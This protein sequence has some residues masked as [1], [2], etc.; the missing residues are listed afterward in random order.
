VP[1]QPQHLARLRARLRDYL[2]LFCP[3]AQ[4]VWDV[5]LC[6]HEACLAAMSHSRSAPEIEVFLGFRGADLQTVVRVRGR[7][8][9]IVALESELLPDSEDEQGRG[10]FLMAQLAD[11]AELRRNGGLEVRL[12][13]R[14]ALGPDEGHEVGESGAV[15]G[16][17]IA[18]EAAAGR[19]RSV[20]DEDR[21]GVIFDNV[22]EGVAL[23]ELVEHEGRPVDYRI[24]QTN[25][26]FR[27]QTG[28]D[29]HGIGSS[30]AGELYG[31]DEPPYLEQ[32]AALAAG[33]VPRVFEVRAPAT[34]RDLRL[35]ALALGAGRFATITEDVTVRERA[36]SMLDEAAA[37]LE[38]AATERRRLRDALT[39]QAETIGEREA[40][41]AAQGRRSAELS[42]ELA[43]LE[44][45]QRQGSPGGNGNKPS[46]PPPT[47][48]QLTQAQELVE[49]VG[50]AKALNAIDR[51]LRSALDV[52][53][54]MQRALEGA[55]QALAADAGTIVLR[56]GS[57]WVVTYQWGFSAAE[58][59]LRVSG[60]EAADAT[61]A[62]AQG[63]PFA[64][65]DMQTA[66]SDVGFPGG[67]D[68]RGVL[69]VPLVVQEAV[70]G[71]LLFYSEQER[72]F[73]NAEIDFGRKLGV[74][75]ALTLENA[76]LRGEQH[77][78]AATLQQRLIHSLPKVAGLEMAAVSRSASD[79]ALLGGAF[80]D[81]IALQDGLMLALI[82][83][84]TGRGIA[85]AV[86]TETMRSSFRTLALI[87]SAP[88]F[89]LRQLNRSLLVEP[90]KDQP[91]T[92]L[93]A[94]FDLSAG[95]LSLASAG[96]PPAVLVS[97]TGARLLEV[98][99]GPP[100]GVLETGYETRQQP[101][102]AGETLVL[103]TKGVTEARHEGGELRLLALLD[104][105]KT[106]EP[107]ALAD[108]LLGA[109]T[110]D[111]GTLQAAVQI[112]TVRRRG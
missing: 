44:G 48:G 108:H 112:V 16:D 78:M 68:L 86:M 88:E 1:A 71:C 104:E 39:A 34:G 49:R 82:G 6:I 11:E 35:T 69:A 60:S 29:V 47:K 7:G 56:D 32:L 59:G 73:A 81:V 63:E 83:E 107:Q 15:A 45:L 72:T 103:Y 89:I 3:E 10:L 31:P 96:H 90:H 92:A 5:V 74:G 105:A 98:L 58:V 110:G 77:A 36:V 50:L 76:L 40:E 101:F 61:A 4:P 87:S 94:R 102:R 84:V 79:P 8:F 33:G 62:M 14:G 111:A 27:R 26:A 2:E 97:A 9:A 30:L 42:A 25:L 80:H 66:A 67:H 91:A 52:H 37:A 85:A 64:M 54:I 70:I 53:E 51:L 12:L 18:E 100:L 24:L 75:I 38:E 23:C 17:V 22:S 106:T 46:G 93:L 43:V 109:V 20:A 41:L 65:A 21:L 28:L 99:Q 95:L 55:V 13:K 19:K 57:D